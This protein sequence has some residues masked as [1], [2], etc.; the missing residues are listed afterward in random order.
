[1]ARVFY[2]PCCILLRTSAFHLAI[3]APIFPQIRVEVS[4]KVYYVKISKKVS[5]ILVKIT[6]MLGI[7]IE[8]LTLVFFV[9][10]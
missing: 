1:M 6:D 7:K 5:T 2:A 8:V 3:R 9:G 4:N 10:H